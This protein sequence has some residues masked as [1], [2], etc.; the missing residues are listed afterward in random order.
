M[1]ST[2]LQMIFNIIPNNSTV[3]DVGC[4]HAYL[5]IEL[6]KQK[7]SSKVYALDNKKGPLNQAKINIE[8]EELSSQIDL[9]LMNGLSDFREKADTIVIAGMGVETAIEIL[10][11]SYQDVNQFSQIIIQVNKNTDRIREWIAKKGYFILDEDICFEDFYYQ[12]VVFTAIKKGSYL[13][14]ELLLGPILMKKK[15]D[16]YLDFIR[17]EIKKIDFILIHRNDEELKE[18][19]Q[20]YSTFV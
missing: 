3:V 12:V 6:I 16:C 15:S 7:K 2:R 4:D 13:Q 17:N 14:E 10:E 9:V 20:I 19:R 1:L 18:K 11:N 5:A 8:Q